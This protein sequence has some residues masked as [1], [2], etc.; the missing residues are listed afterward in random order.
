[1][2]K[3]I[4]YSSVF[5]LVLLNS[6]AFSQYEGD[7]ETKS[8]TIIISTKSYRSALRK[9]QEAA[10]KLVIPM[11]LRSLTPDKEQGLTSNEVCGCGEKHGYISRGRYEDGKYISIEYSSAFEGFS[12]GYYIVVV[13]S[14]YHDA[15]NETLPSIKK[16]YKDAY[17]KDSEV[18]MGCSH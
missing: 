5:L 8:F 15:L 12:K 17:I 16:Q 14:G 3:S 11:D 9:A 10:N 18:Y 7:F 1:M 13:Q 4:I 2:V 6:F